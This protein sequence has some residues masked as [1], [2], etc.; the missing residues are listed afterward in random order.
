MKYLVTGGAG[1][2]GSH[3][4][5]QLLSLGHEVIAVDNFDVTLRPADQRKDWWQSAQS[6]QGIQ[7]VSADLTEYPI[8]RLLSGVDIVIHQAATPGLV[9]SWVAFDRYLRNNVLAT[10]LL[11]Q[12]VSQSA[13]KKVVHASTSS[14]YGLTAVGDESLQPNP[15]SPYGISKL[16]SEMIWAS[17]K[18]VLPCPVTTLRYFSVYGPR[19]RTDMAWSIFIGQLMANQQI[20]ITG[21]GTQSRTATYVGDAAAATI[22]ASDLQAP[23]GLYNICGDEEITVTEALNRIAQLLDIEPNVVYTSRRRGDQAQTRGINSAAKKELGFENR[24]TVAEGIQAQVNWAK[25]HPYW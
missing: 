24:T 2:I 21:D 6:R 8:N 3:I 16:A 10:Q 5:E 18:D 4:V 9:P 20:Q 19:Q 15:I 17:Y 22:A 23:D 11:A 1:F 14:V 12:A 13:V 25:Q 7:L